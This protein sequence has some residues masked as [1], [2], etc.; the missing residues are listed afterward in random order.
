MY[1]TQSY[2]TDHITR[3]ISLLFTTMS[4]IHRVLH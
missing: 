3:Y 4:D 2:Q 1:I